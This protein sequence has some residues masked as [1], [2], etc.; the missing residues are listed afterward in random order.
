MD[1]DPAVPRSVSK[2]FLVGSVVHIWVVCHHWDD[3]G[4]KR[5][6]LCSIHF[7]LY[8]GWSA[9]IDHLFSR[10][11]EN[12]NQILLND[13]KK[14]SMQPHD[15]RF[16]NHEKQQK[17]LNS[18]Q[19]APLTLNPKN[20]LDGDTSGGK[21]IGKDHETCHDYRLSQNPWCSDQKVELNSDYHEV[22]RF[23]NK[24][25]VMIEHQLK[26]FG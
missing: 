15:I 23:S 10:W 5:L 25:K 4:L 14:I 8:L 26:S 16:Q 13:F 24:N 17:S 7:S 21:R 12:N 19:V 3:V 18:K 1:S 6:T 22:G 9:E 11:L 20:W 2:T